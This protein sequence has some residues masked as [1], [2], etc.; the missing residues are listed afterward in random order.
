M[1]YIASGKSEGAKLEYG[2][3]RLGE[4]GYFLQPTIFSNVQDQMEI[5]REE[6]R[7]IIFILLIFFVFPFRSLDQ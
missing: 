4:K 6:V 1:N 3:E 2:G 7:S 5:A